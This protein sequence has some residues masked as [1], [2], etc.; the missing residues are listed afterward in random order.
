VRGEHILSPKEYALCEVVTF[1][2]VALPKVVSGQLYLHSVPGRN[3][4]FEDAREEIARRKIVRVI[5][6]APLEEVRHTSSDYALAIEAGQLPWMEEPFPVPDF[7]AP[8]DLEKFFR[9]A[10]SVANH[11]RNGRS[12]L[13]H[14]G[15]GIGRTG[16]L[17]VCVLIVL[18]MTPKQADKTVRRAGSRPG[19]ESQM[20][21]IQGVAEK[22]RVNEI[23]K[24]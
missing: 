9:L 21:V 6:L 15:A 22:I 3:E 17:A 7:E 20:K 5:R 11:L 24:S 18:E 2:S 13:I 19:V 12:V 16:T 10:G 4:P 14:C 23:M 1:R 8:A